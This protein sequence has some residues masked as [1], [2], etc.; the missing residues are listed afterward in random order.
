MMTSATEKILAEYPLAWSAHD[1]DKLLTFF[2][3]DCIYADPTLGV[4]KRGKDGI[5]EFAKE[6]FSMQP[7]FHIEYSQSF[8]TET[9]GAAIWTISNTWNGEF[10][11]VDVTGTK[12][13]FIGT[14][15]FEFKNGLISRNTDYWDLTPLMLQLGVMTTNLRACK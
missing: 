7:D 13:S 14:T 11:G 4:E 2:N 8:A 5:L 1:L 10:H 9:H 15:M 12:V 3:D 6:I